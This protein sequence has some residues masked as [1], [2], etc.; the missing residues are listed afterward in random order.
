[1]ALITDPDDIGY[2]LTYTG[3]VEMHVDLAAKTVRLTRVGALSTDGI[4]LKAVYSKLKD[5]WK[6]DAEAVKYKFPMVPITDE[7]FE[8]ADSWDFY[9]TGSGSDYTPNLIRTGGWARKNSGG[10]TLEMWA[11]IISLGNIQAGGQPYFSQF[12][13]D[14]AHDFNLTGAIN[15]AIQIYSDPNGDGSTADGFDY[16]SYLSLFIRTQ[17]NTYAAST[18]ADIGVTGNMAYQAYRFPLADADDSK[19]ATADIDIDANSDGVP[20][21]APYSGMSITWYAAA[22]SR[23]INGVA[24]DFHVIID[25]NQGTLQE[26]YEFVQFQLRQTLDIDAGSGTKVGKL[27]NAL[28]E[29][30]GS[31]LYTKLDSTGG[32]YVDDYQVGD[33][34]LIH[35]RDDTGTIRDNA[36][37]ATIS[38]SFGDNLVN[39]VDAIYKVFFTN[40]DAG[41]NLGY[42]FGTANA[43]VMQDASAAAMSGSVS[44][45]AIQHT[46]DYDNNVQR[47]AGSDGE[48]VPITVVAIGLST[49]QYVQAT[50]T[51]TASLAVTLSL[52]AALERNYQP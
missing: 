11:G 24:R 34:N 44:G 4:T 22:Q 30:V 52:A 42:D 41:L 13:G 46:Y 16:R 26:I 47:G 25:G 12:A 14:T 3:A 20:D 49:G 37:V 32:V 29:F 48:P 1:M 10:V 28:L 6:T 50:G 36:R 7:Q 31:D 38:L 51:L 33:T 43:I 17:G 2:E 9:K 21:V 18:L 40:D 8:F 15:Q 45:A 27:T 39:D 23:T 19:I 35:F 5:I